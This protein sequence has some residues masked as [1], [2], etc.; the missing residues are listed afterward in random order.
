VGLLPEAPGAVD[1]PF[2][3]AVAD[4]EADGGR[5]LAAVEILEEFL[6]V[7]AAQ[8]P[9]VE[10][11]L[12]LQ[13]GVGAGVGAFGGRLVVLRPVLEQIG[14]QVAD[15]VFPP[16]PVLAAALHHLGFAG[17]AIGLALA[18]LGAGALLQPLLALGPELELGLQGPHDIVLEGHQ[19]PP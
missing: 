8:Q 7:E 9:Q 11:A 2:P 4:G 14:Q 17:G 6:R 5:G 16:A 10:P 15:G 1:D 12:V 19:I 18:A 3:I 13:V